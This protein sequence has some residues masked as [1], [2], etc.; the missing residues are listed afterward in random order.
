M[1]YFASGRARY[2]LRPG[3]EWAGVVEAVGDGVDPVWLGRR[4]TGDTMLADGTCDRCRTGRRHV[5]RNLA[6]VGISMGVD[7][8]LAERLVVPADSL[9][10]LPD[11][12]R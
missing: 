1:A 3:H 10:E 4:V 11:A 8:A 6:E 12:R 2:P 5:C 7:G 9:L